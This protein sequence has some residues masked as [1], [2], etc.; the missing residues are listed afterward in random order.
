MG[1]LP[2]PQP[3]GPSKPAA[4]PHPA[5]PLQGSLLGPA[6]AQGG[7]WPGRPLWEG[8]IFPLKARSWRIRLNPL[9]QSG[10]RVGG[11]PTCQGAGCTHSALTA[12]DF[13]AEYLSEL[14]KRFFPF[15]PF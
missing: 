8:C 3:R 7:L 6:E 14:F 15:F 5:R 1:P 9:T 2:A 10:G 13:R 12:R 4:C 11:A